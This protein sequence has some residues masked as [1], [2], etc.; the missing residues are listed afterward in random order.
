MRVSAGIGSGWAR[1]LGHC[2]TLGMREEDGI[3]ITNLVKKAQDGPPP[4][5]PAGVQGLPLQSACQLV[6]PQFR[7]PGCGAPG[8]APLAGDTDVALPDLRTRQSEGPRWTDD[9][10]SDEICPS[11]GLQLRLRRDGA[12]S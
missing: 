12:P 4:R 7:L 2:R 3:E 6:H 5:A 1:A 9:E 10:P 8:Y 11:C